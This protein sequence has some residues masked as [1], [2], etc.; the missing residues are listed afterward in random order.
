MTKELF[1]FEVCFSSPQ[2]TDQLW[3][4]LTLLCTGC[5][6]YNSHSPSIYCQG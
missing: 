3:G 6:W 1:D 4:P 5:Q 2:C